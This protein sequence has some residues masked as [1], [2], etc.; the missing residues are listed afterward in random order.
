MDEED[1]VIF[2]YTSVACNSHNSFTLHE[3]EESMG[4][5]VNP[6]VGVWDVLVTKQAKLHPFKTLTNFTLVEFDELVPTILAHA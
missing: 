6:R 2:D 1:M 3:I 5:V 4:Q